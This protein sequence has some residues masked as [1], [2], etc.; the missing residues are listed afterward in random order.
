[1]QNMEKALNKKTCKQLLK[2]K[3][4]L[5][6]SFSFLAFR[7]NLTGKSPVEIDIKKIKYKNGLIRRSDV[8]NL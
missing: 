3:I 7:K 2:R 8:K 6:E 1:M 4:F 5:D